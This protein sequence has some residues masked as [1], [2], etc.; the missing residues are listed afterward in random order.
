VNQFIRVKRTLLISRVLVIPNRWRK[1]GHSRQC[2][3]YS[4]RSFHSEKG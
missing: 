3:C 4:C 2:D 1:S